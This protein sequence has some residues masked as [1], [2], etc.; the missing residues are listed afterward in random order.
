M[1]IPKEH[2]Q[3]LAE[4]HAEMMDVEGWRLCKDQPKTQVRFYYN[5]RIPKTWYYVDFTDPNIYMEILKWAAN[6]WGFDFHV[7]CC[8][9][10]DTWSVMFD[11]PKISTNS[12]DQI[13]AIASALFQIKEK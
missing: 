2:L 7:C 10:T 9:C 4:M 5:S 11:D 12:D 3:N 13:T 1:T 6:K 8:R